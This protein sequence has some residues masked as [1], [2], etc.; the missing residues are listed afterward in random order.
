MRQLL[1]LLLIA[2]TAYAA[3]SV[4]RFDQTTAFESAEVKF[5]DRSSTGLA[6]V[7][8]SCPSSPHYDG[9]C[10]TIVPTGQCTISS[11]SWVITRGQSATLSWQGPGA[12]ISGSISPGIGS[13]AESGSQTVS[14]QST[15]VYRYTGTYRWGLVFRSNFECDTTISVLPPTHCPEGQVL[16]GDGLCRN[17]QCPAGQTLGSDGLCTTVACPTGYTLGS[18]GQCQANNCPATMY[19]C[20]TGETANS[21][22]QRSYSAAPA[23]APTNSLYAVCTYGCSGGACNPAPA[24]ADAT[25]TV[26]PML[27]RRGGT[28]QVTWN[29][30]DTIS[31]TV[32]STGGDAWTGRFGTLLSSPIMQQTTFTLTC[33]A[34][35]RSVGAAGATITRTAT[36]NVIP[37]FDEQ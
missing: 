11:S 1:S 3:L 31:C 26:R 9:E 34:R 10:D 18:N 25:L 28:V 13:V 35:S 24:A 37:I 8:A 4:A 20:G 17:P 29:S 16:G 22:Y 2:C 12:Y 33:I 23:C 36:V 5:A 19:Y 6:I 27:V 32:T 14:P 7:P 21:L 15:T 30:V